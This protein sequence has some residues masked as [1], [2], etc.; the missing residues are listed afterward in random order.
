[1]TTKRTL[2]SREDGGAPWLL[3]M[4]FAATLAMLCAIVAIGR[5][6]SDWVEAGA[7]VLLLALLALLTQSLRRLSSDGDPS[8]P[9]SSDDE[10]H[11]DRSASVGES[12]AAR[13]AG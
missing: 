9:A 1:M 3:L 5:T 2:P 10:H 6:D 12:R 11:T 8:T 4:F 7:I 13:S